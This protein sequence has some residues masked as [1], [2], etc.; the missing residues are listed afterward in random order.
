MPVTERILTKVESVTLG[1]GLVPSTS[2]WKSDLVVDSTVGVVSPRLARSKGS[3]GF[4]SSG[5]LTPPG[6]EMH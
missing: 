1:M 3:M 4:R 6:Y 2:S 5:S